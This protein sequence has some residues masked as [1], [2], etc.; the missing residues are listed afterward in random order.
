MKQ[1]TALK[2]VEIQMVLDPTMV[3]NHFS[4]LFTKVAR[5]L[6]QSL[7]RQ[8][9]IKTKAKN[10]ENR[11]NPENLEAGKPQ[12]NRRNFRQIKIQKPSNLTVF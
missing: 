9:R 10:S 11:E 3:S 8:F 6:I 7:L 5:L 2:S 4:E 12:R 1:L